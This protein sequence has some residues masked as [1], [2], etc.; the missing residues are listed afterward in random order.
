MRSRHAA[1]S[2]GKKGRSHSLCNLIRNLERLNKDLLSKLPSWECGSNEIPC[3]R[4]VAIF[5]LNKNGMGCAFAFRALLTGGRWGTPSLPHW[6]LPFLP[7]DPSST[8]E[9]QAAVA[10]FLLLSRYPLLCSVLSLSGI[11]LIECDGW[12]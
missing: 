1:S 9:L 12:E 3:S 7:E 5:L 8:D 6:M 2:N 4:R 10:P 11:V